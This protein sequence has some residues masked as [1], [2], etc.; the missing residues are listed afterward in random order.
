MI[1]IVMPVDFLFFAIGVLCV[2]IGPRK[3]GKTNN[4][5]T[6]FSHHDGGFI[7]MN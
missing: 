3:I 2:R 1:L 4:M 6:G 7:K 5:A